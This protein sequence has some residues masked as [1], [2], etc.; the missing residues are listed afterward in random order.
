[1]V[2]SF[3]QGRKEEFVEGIKD[4]TV[5]A[6]RGMRI[7]FPSAGCA[8]SLAALRLDPDRKICNGLSHSPLFRLGSAASPKADSKVG[9]IEG[10]LM[11]C[12]ILDGRSQTSNAI[13]RK[14]AASGSRAT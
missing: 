9:K 5:C 7:L 2:R 4:L 12:A 3:L 11:A 13:L 6:S 14:G 10:G 1:M 8:K